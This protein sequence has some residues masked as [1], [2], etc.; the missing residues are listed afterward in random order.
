MPPI[1]DWGSCQWGGGA[2]SSI[3]P[4]LLKAV[5]PLP[6][7][8]PQ[9]RYLGLRPEASGK[10]AAGA[11]CQVPRDFAQTSVPGCVST[12][13]AED[14][15][16]CECPTPCQTHSPAW[17]CGSRAT[18]EKK[19]ATAPS[20]GEGG[21]GGKTAQ[22]CI[23]SPL[24]SMA[25]SCGAGPLVPHFTPTSWGKA[26][27]EAR[28]AWYGRGWGPRPRGGSQQHATT[29]LTLGKPPTRF[30]GD[31]AGGPELGP[32]RTSQ[33]VDARPERHRGAP[34][35]IGQ[36]PRDHLSPMPT[37]RMAPAAESPRRAPGSNSTE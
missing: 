18:A 5:V 23:P 4:A 13:G 24:S 12:C 21:L 9:S 26:I 10:V 11:P 35:N 19:L 31:W 37:R 15:H 34:C 36:R 20:R 17:A 1:S 6:L 33:D 25:H 30:H 3:R 2:I 14:L 29:L 28:P 22:Q 7:P 32:E 27:L 16:M 8:P